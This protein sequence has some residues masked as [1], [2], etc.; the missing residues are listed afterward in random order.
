M[1][2]KQIL[3]LIWNSILNQSQDAKKTL[4]N[5]IV[6]MYRLGL[7]NCIVHERIYQLSYKSLYMAMNKEPIIHRFYN[8]MTNDIWLS[9]ERIK[10]IFCGNPCNVF[11]GSK[12]NIIENLLGFKGIGL[13]KAEIAFAVASLYKGIFVKN[14]KER[15]IRI[16]P[17]L[18]ET[19]DLEVD[20]L[21]S[22]KS[23]IDFN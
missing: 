20:I 15:I 13:H 9:V 22:L 10:H 11:V 4:N 5:T 1:N 16:C 12:D 3:F 19:I 6:L 21:N 14:Y 8:K 17:S 23:G 2:D 18:A 7:I